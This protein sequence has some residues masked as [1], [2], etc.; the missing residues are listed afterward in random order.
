[1]TAARRGFC[2]SAGAFERKRDTQG[3]FEF[4]WKV[5]KG[6]LACGLVRVGAGI[7]STEAE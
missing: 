4:S 6:F 1:M 3:C 5:G 2:L 7:R